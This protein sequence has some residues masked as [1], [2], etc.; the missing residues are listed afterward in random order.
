MGL[1]LTCVRA[2]QQGAPRTGLD[3]AFRLSFEGRVNYKQAFL[4][5]VFNLSV[6]SSLAFQMFKLV[7]SPPPPPMPVLW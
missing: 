1:V 5:W 3:K 7:N 4:L 2:P 6:I